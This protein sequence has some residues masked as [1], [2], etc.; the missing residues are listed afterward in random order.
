MNNIQANGILTVGISGIVVDAAAIV[1]ITGRVDIMSTTV[2]N[3]ARR[4][5]RP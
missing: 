4:F 5:F 3:R 2:P 1:D